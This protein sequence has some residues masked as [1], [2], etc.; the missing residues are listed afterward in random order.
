ME[1][2]ARANKSFWRTE[3]AASGNLGT[4]TEQREQVNWRN[5]VRNTTFRLREDS[6]MKEGQ[7]GT[8][9]IRLEPS[10]DVRNLLDTRYDSFPHQT[11]QSQTQGDHQRSS[12]RMNQTRSE[13][14]EKPPKL[15]KSFSGTPAEEGCCEF[16]EFEYMVA[17]VRNRYTDD[18]IKEAVMLALRGSAFSLV[19]NL[20]VMTPLDD[21]MAALRSSFAAVK[22]PDVTGREF[23]NMNQEQDEEVSAFRTRLELGVNEWARVEEIVNL[24]P[25]T[26]DRFMVRRFFGGLR[27]GIVLHLNHLRGKPGITFQEVFDEARKVEQRLRTHRVRIKE[28]KDSKKEE[29]KQLTPQPEQQ[30]QKRYGGHPTGSFVPTTTGPYQRP[31]V[32]QQQYNT[33]PTQQNQYQ[34][35]PGAQPAQPVQQASVQIPYEAYRAGTEQQQVQP[36]LAV[37]MAPCTGMTDCVCPRHSFQNKQDGEYG[38]P[39]W[40]MQGNPLCWRCY[41]YG[42]LKRECQAKRVRMRPAENAQGTAPAGN[43]RPQN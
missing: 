43:D 39:N 1:M 26:R 42:H 38:L 33:P 41:T 40:D 20:G 24:T 21:I 11:T 12:Y 15:A 25:V 8:S 28:E 35:T 13:K 23:F 5:P 18:A 29:K 37:Q 9:Q 34:A 32:S 14:I 30:P 10:Q 7:T 17:S 36:L 31:A 16:K 3:R 2:D 6:Q 4:G 27:A 22:E 19:L